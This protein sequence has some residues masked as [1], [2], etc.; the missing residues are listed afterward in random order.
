MSEESS[1]NYLFEQLYDHF[2]TSFIQDKLKEFCH[3]GHYQIGI[4]KDVMLVGSQRDEF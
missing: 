3:G 2:D 4:N 1:L